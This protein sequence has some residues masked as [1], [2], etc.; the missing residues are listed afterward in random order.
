MPSST[1]DQLLKSPYG[2]VTKW[3]S[4]QSVGISIKRECLE[5]VI[6][7]MLGLGLFEKKQGGNWILSP[8]GERRL[9]QQKA[10]FKP[11]S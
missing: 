7:Q 9:V 2:T 10:V 11:G 8:A 1:I 5:A 3:Y 6:L 4:G